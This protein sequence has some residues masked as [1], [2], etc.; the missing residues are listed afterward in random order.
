M[1]VPWP[2]RLRDG[3]YEF[4]GISH[5][6]PLSEPAK[7]NAIHGF[8]RWENWTVGGRGHDWVV[9]DH[10]LRP[11]EGY[12]FSLHLRVEY[13]LAQSGLTST[14]IATNT[15]D[16]ACPYGMGTHPYLRVESVTLDDCWLEAPGGQHLLVDDRAIPIGIADVGGTPYDF[17]ARRRIHGTE[18][19]TTFVVS[20]RDPD[21]RAWVRLS[22]DGEQAGVGLWMDEQYPYYMLFT[23]DS[24]PERG[25][26]RRSLGVEPMTC[27]P[28][29][30]NSGEGLIA[31][32]PAASVTSRWGIAPLARS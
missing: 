21:G 28:N 1:L 4:E 15:G 24:L 27:A 22:A 3:R 16:R 11:R 14:V 6:V 17:R 25:R 5:Q 9:M 13:R 2:N 10:M 12:P 20:T 18:L 23:G 7:R 8:L 29:A 31:L 32:A 26:R 30:F 19:D